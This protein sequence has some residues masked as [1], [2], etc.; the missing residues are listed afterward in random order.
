MHHVC[1][2][3][4]VQVLSAVLGT[5]VK[6]GHLSA[7]AARGVEFTTLKTVRPKWDISGGAQPGLRRR[8]PDAILLAH[9][10][11]AGDK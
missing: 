7:N 1:T 11:P 4:Y 10:A 6:L 8:A 2:C 5:A 3:A 9:R